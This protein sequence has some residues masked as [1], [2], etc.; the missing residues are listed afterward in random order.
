[1]RFLDDPNCLQTYL[2]PLDSSFVHVWLVE[3]LSAESVADGPELVRQ[4]SELL[5][6]MSYVD[7]I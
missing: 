6:R 2:G 1:M 3:D 7:S 5:S 4:A